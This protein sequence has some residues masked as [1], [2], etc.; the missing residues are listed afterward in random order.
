MENKKVIIIGCHSGAGIGSAQCVEM[1]LAALEEKHKHKVEVV[2]LVDSEKS[3]LKAFAN[4]LLSMDRREVQQ[5]LEIQKIEL[6]NPI[7]K[8]DYR[9]IQK[10]NSQCGWKNRPKH[11]R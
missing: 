7:Q 3:D 4:E 1:A 10:Q 2:N 5:H 11:K 6:I 8:C 9:N